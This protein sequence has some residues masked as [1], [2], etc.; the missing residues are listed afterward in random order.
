MYPLVSIIIPTKNSA[1][2]LEDCLVSVKNQTYQNIEIIVVDNFSSDDTPLV[3]QKYATLFLEKWPER[4]TQ[5]NYWLSQ[6]TGEYCA[7]IDSDM[8]LESIVIAECCEILKSDKKIGG[9]CIGEKSV[10]EWFFVRLRD[11]ERSFYAWA[12][13]ESA[14]FFRTEDV[15]LVGGFEEDI[16]FF[17]ESLLP[18]KIESKLELSCTARTKSYILHQEGNIRLVSWL[19]KKFY[20]G[21]S[22]WTYE[23]KIRE[24]WI[25]K[26]GNDQMNIISRYALFLKQKRFYSRPILAIGVL[27]LKTLEFGAGWMGYIYNKFR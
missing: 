4:T 18:Q 19:Q 24:I 8:I 15:R 11:F 23:K 3:A 9:V 1:K 13:V 5:K 7:F 10:G 2:T 25:E 14:R 6:S 27:T 12:S 22:L 20:Y 21:K 17:E 26:R 16:I